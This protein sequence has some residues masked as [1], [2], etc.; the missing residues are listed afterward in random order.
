[1]ESVEDEKKIYRIHEV[2]EC[3]SRRNAGGY[4]LKREI[5]KNCT[6][7]IPTDVEFVEDWILDFHFFFILLLR[8]Y[9]HKDGSVTRGKR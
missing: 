8:N 4:I 6:T 1:M 9:I 7:G 2:K 3:D 5:I